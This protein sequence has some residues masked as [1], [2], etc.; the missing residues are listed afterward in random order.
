MKIN[1]HQYGDTHTVL[2][3]GSKWPVKRMHSLDFT[4]T[5]CDRIFERDD[6]ARK[7]AI[8]CGDGGEFGVSLA[9]EEKSSVHGRFD[10]PHSHKPPEES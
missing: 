3:L 4:D 2:G 8:A 6:A 5:P 10:R 9:R 7:L 1:G